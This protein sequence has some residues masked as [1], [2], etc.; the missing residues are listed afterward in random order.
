MDKQT[1][2]PTSSTSLSNLSKRQ[3]IAKSN[4]MIFVWV[5]LAAVVI[6]SCAVAFV[7]LGR[8]AI[9]N[10]KIINQKIKTNALVVQNIENAKT[11]KKNVDALIADDNLA[12]ARA[13]PS[14]NN[15]KV[16]F[17]ALPTNGD[18]TTLS[19]TLYTQIFQRAGVS[20]ES[21]SVGDVAAS[22]AAVAAS[23]IAPSDAST[24]VSAP[25]PQP[26]TFRATVKGGTD[27]ITTMFSHLE[28]VIRPMSISLVDIRATSD[29]QLTIT[30]TGETYFVDTDTVKLGTTVVK[31]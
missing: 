6:V 12:A 7:F 16:I 3:Q 14:D 9:F 26:V 21:I 2:Q 30:L 28:H 11:L 1:A 19:N 13:V 23:P 10:Q 5:T 25:L 4:Q 31:P 17:D 24:T 29:G 20:T 8:Q 27:T 15:L 22:S 18:T